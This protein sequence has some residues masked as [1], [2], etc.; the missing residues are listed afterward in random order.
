MIIM[1][2][3]DWKKEEDNFGTLK[4]RHSR[5]LVTVSTSLRSIT[6]SQTKMSMAHWKATQKPVTGFCCVY[7]SPGERFCVWEAGTIPWSVPPCPGLAPQ[8]TP[9]SASSSGHAA[10][11]QSGTSPPPCNISLFVLLSLSLSVCLSVCLSVSLSLC[12]LKTFVFLFFFRLVSV[13]HY[14]GIRWI[15][16]VLLDYLAV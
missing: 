11:A 10:S 2:V 15:P 7:H 6:S 16:G 13:S 5:K 14:M 8:Q 1:S 12:F 4:R 3:H 9:P